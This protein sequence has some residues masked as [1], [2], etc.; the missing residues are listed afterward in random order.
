MDMDPED[1]VLC[2]GGSENVVVLAVIGG[3]DNVVAA[4]SSPYRT[5]LLL[6]VG[7]GSISS[8]FSPGP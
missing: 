1:L 2:N 4:S 3:G 5:V 8:I 7:V 6:S